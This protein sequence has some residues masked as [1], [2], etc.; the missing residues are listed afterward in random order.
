MTLDTKDLPQQP[1]PEFEDQSREMAKIAV[2]AIPVVGGAGAALLEAVFKSPLE[3]R[4]IRWFDSLADAIRELRDK[5]EG[6]DDESLR[7][8][9]TFVTVAMQASQIA[10]RNHQQEKLDALRNA[11]LNSRLPNSPNEDTQ[12]I[13]LEVI[14]RLTPSHMHILAL[15]DNPQGHTEERGIS[16]DDLLAGSVRKL[17]EDVFPEF[18]G[19]RD[20]YNQ[21]V[22][23]LH[24]A[25]LS[26][27]EDVGV[28][29]AGSSMLARRTTEWGHRFIQ[30]ISE[31]PEL[32]E[33]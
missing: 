32:R 30:F 18:A 22:R 4:K 9:E 2:S 11:V 3:Q 20:F 8:D 6:L 12:L 23:D 25:G 1:E 33:D 26:K 5:V 7:D 19:Q 21:V 10:L 28:N 24:T 31:P 16:Y 29:V 17:I 14:D 15:F 27:V 13:F